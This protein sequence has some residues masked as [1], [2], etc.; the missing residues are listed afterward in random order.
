MFKLT[1]RETAAFDTAMI[2]AGIVPESAARGFNAMSA[3]IQAGGKHIEDAF[4]NIGL[5]RE[6]FMQDLE[7]D[8]TGTLVRFFDVLAKSE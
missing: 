7:K 4:A 2:S 1:A 8:A 5:S 3:R 6:K